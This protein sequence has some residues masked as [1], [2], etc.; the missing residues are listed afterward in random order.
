MWKKKPNEKQ[1]A[2]LRLGYLLSKTKDRKEELS[3]K[4][5][6]NKFGFSTKKVKGKKNINWKGEKVKYSGIHKWISY[7]FGKANKCEN[8]DCTGIYKKYEWSNISGKYRRS[9]KD[10]EQLCISCH[11]KKNP[12]KKQK[13]TTYEK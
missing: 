3:K 7:N 5:V 2:G 11:R 1:L 8:K 4:M 10:W 6:G 9:I 13:T 12:R